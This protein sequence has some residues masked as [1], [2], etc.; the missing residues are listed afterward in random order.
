VFGPVGS[1]GTPESEGMYE[2]F[3]ADGI[4][5]FVHRDVVTEMRVPGILRFHLG[6]LGW[7]E[8]SLTPPSGDADPG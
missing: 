2:E 1:L 8:I 5:I 6:Q 3:D 7:S 4:L